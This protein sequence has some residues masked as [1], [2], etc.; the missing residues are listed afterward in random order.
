MFLQ[1]VSA[2]RSVSLKRYPAR[3]KVIY[4][5][6]IWINTFDK[7]RQMLME[8]LASIPCQVIPLQLIPA[9]GQKTP[10]I[11]R[12]D[13][14]SARDTNNWARGYSLQTVRCKS[15]TLADIAA[16][17]VCQRVLWITLRCRSFGRSVHTRLTPPFRP[18]ATTLV[19]TVPNWKICFSN[20]FYRSFFVRLKSISRCYL[21][22][23]VQKDWKT[24]WTFS[25]LSSLKQFSFKEFARA[26]NAQID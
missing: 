5:P 15:F 6:N 20:F 8:R 25:L 10:H 9:V 24:S 18:A 16:S 1:T 4:S 7:S 22:G 19:I 26:S 12:L 14:S 17:R 2:I 3:R 11:R 23:G 13:L 21:S